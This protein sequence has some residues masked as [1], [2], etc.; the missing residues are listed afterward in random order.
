MNIGDNSDY[1]LLKVALLNRYRLTDAAFRDRFRQTKPEDGKSFSQFANRVTGY[2]D[3]WIELI[4]TPWIFD[5]VRYLIIRE[6]VL[7][8]GSTDVRVFIG[9]RTPD[10]FK[11][12]C[13]IA[14][15]YLKAYRK[16]FRHWWM[17]NKSKSECRDVRGQEREK[18]R[19]MGIPNRFRSSSGQSRQYNPST[20]STGRTCWICGSA[21][22]CARDSPQNMY[23]TPTSE[24]K[25][26]VGPN[27]TTLACE[28]ALFFIVCHRNHKTVNTHRGLHQY[29][30]LPHGVAS[31]PAV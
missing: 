23:K 20:S 29:Q 11:E 28:D 1:D 27:V 25:N 24:S 17:P 18:N 6:Q 21:R 19:P 9:E 7:G 30:R 5:G 15:Q 3:R 8:V 22:H 31:A 12:M 26:R 13:G 16:S 14:E 10:S 4:E 2:L